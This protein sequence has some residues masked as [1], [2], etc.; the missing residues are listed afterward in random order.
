MSDEAS[1]L[2]SDR[3]ALLGR[4]WNDPLYRNGYYLVASSVLSS[5]FG[6]VFWMLAANLF[7]PEVIGVG[8]SA[9]AA[10]T[11]LTNLSSFNL[12]NGLNRFVPRAGHATGR[13]IG[14]SY[15]V[16]A[17][18]GLAV[19]GVYLV[20]INLWSPT[21]GFLRDTPAMALWFPLAVGSWAVFTLQDGALTG[22]RASGWVAIENL[23][24]AIAKILVLVALA[25]SLVESLADSTVFM[26]W[27]LPLL[28]IVIGVNVLMYRRLIPRHAEA[29]S[30]I[31]EDVTGS[32]VRRFVAGD[33]SASLVWMATVNLLPII[34]LERAGPTSAAYFYL[35]WTVAYVLYLVGRNFGMSMLTE[36]SSDPA[37]TAL[38]TYR[39]LRQTLVLVVPA[40]A[41]LIMVAPL[42]LRLF[43]SEYSTEGATLLRLLS[44]GAIPALV[45][46]T[47][48]SLLRAE[49]RVT[50]LVVVMA[51]QAVLVLGLTWVL[52][53]VMGITGVGVAWLVGQTLVAAVLLAT[54]LR[55]VVLANLSP[56]LVETLGA[57][58][59][60]VRRFGGRR[61]DFAFA[62]SAISS[63]D[64]PGEPTGWVPMESLSSLSDAR[65]VVVGDGV[66]PRA[67]IKT[68]RSENGEMSLR[69]SAEALESAA[70]DARLADLWPS[71]PVT[72]G[73]GR[74]GDR[75]YVIEAHLPGKPA[76]ALGPTHQVIPSATEQ[77]AQWASRL[78]AAT[79]DRTAG[80]LPWFDRRVAIIAHRLAADGAPDS[81]I[82]RLDEL[83]VHLRA[84]LD[85]MPSSMI[86]GDF[87]LGNVL[88]DPHSGRL[89]GVVDW[90]ASDRAGPIDFDLVTLILTTRVFTSQRETGVVVRGIVDGIEP[91]LDDELR[92][93]ESSLD[94]DWATSTDAVL[95]TWL[96]SAALNMEKS[97]RYQ[98]GSPWFVRNF[99][100]VLTRL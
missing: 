1:S 68:A 49:R 65:A 21:L 66:H 100:S 14:M 40:V 97:D 4:H 87:W 79:V 56:R 7:D 5:A 32:A 73:H 24:F 45:T 89:E 39:T 6:L 95:V 28:P 64:A 23:I 99:D 91:W 36:T 42:V 67:I 57:L 93:F 3:L 85:G 78:A 61:A 96:H 71:I 76:V 34:V 30:P 52:L 74:I 33:Y 80:V 46:T 2:I 41:V 90:D 51:S 83:A 11:F 58:R 26:A 48:A 25:S 16:A 55:S 98:F 81:L 63:F 31:A 9:I 22:L 10:M 13:I 15:A 18:V 59:D 94:Q 54:G 53:G 12:V 50:A 47:Y 62:E 29:T 72:L 77:A 35:A 44:L 69:R 84:R 88:V 8:A 19:G 43:G 20:G 70:V 38:L 82:S 17:C 27:T 60:H 92:L 75:S 37:A 86:H